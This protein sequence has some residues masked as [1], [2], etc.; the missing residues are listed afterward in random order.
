MKKNDENSEII[1]EKKPIALFDKAVSVIMISIWLGILLFAVVYYTNPYILIDITKDERKKEASEDV[2]AAIALTE[3]GDY[4]SAIEKYKKALEIYPNHIEAY[5]NMGVTYKTMQDYENAEICLKKA[6]NMDTVTSFNIYKNLYDIANTKKDSGKAEEY[7]GLAICK[8]KYLV[9]KNMLIGT[10][11]L[12]KQKWD[13][14][15]VY[16][17]TALDHRL[18]IK[19]QYYDMLVFSYLNYSNKPEY[20]KDIQ[21]IING[22][23]KNIDFSIYDNRALSLALKNDN[24]LAVNYNRIGFCLAKMNELSKSYNYF[25]KALEIKPNYP[26]ALDNI[27]FVDNLMK[28][29]M[30]TPRKETKDT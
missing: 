27:K 20:R 4:N 13:S 8:N 10:Y 12:N 21:N 25:K 14:A 23:I 26:D 7:I 1:I 17:N 9:D 11:F 16:Y 22:G 28:K 18:N 30:N 19:C 2:I 24:D 15:L 5:V 29:Y 3:N 6:L